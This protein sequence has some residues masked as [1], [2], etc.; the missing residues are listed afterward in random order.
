MAKE[1]RKYQHELLAL[2]HSSPQHRLRMLKSAHLGLVKCICECAL[3]VLKERIPTNKSQKR[4][5]S[6]FK[7]VLRK[8]AA[9]RGSLKHKKRI[10]VQSGGSFLLSLIPIAISALSHRFF[11][12]NIYKRT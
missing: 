7:K 6:R 12:D 10:I 9:K 1:A 8:L 2:C 3:N 4:R 11:P 5:L